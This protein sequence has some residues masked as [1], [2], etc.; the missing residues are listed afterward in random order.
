M[1]YKLGKLPAQADPRR[2]MLAAYSAA[3]L[4]PP[5]E[6]SD[7]T[8]GLTDWGELMNCQ[9]GCCA[10]SA[11][12]HHAMA[13]QLGATKKTTI[14]KDQTIIDA[15]AA[16]TG[17]D[18]VTGRG[19]NGTV[20]LN[21]LEQWR[22]GRITGNQIIASAAIDCRDPVH[23]KEA[24]HFYGG[25]LAGIQMPQSA[26]EQSEANVTWSIPWFSPMVGGHAIAILSYTSKFVWCITWGKIQAMTWEFLMKYLD[27]GYAVIN[28]LWMDAEG[29]SVSGL[30]LDALVAD[31][32]ALNTPSMG[33]P[34]AA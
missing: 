26:M 28:P 29:M 13:W 21:M 1:I 27:E 23:I 5:P 10:Y 24:V 19:D 15:Y 11:A 18:P 16:G 25:V 22:E 20:L 12:G 30:H 14:V 6:T 17:Y 31:L 4:P 9:L 7:R 32:A 2:V 3:A 34:V 8:Y 33:P